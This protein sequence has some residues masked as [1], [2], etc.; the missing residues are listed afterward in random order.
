MIRS[1]RVWSP[2]LGIA[3]SVQVADRDIGCCSQE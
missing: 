1:V 2:G 3:T